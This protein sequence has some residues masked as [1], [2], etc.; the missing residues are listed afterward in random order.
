MC[1]FFGEMIEIQLIINF[2]EHWEG[3]I[4]QD[5]NAEITSVDRNLTYED[6]L[7]IMHEMIKADRKVLFIK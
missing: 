2:S 4:Y 7:S 1:I 5:G 6:L 3:S